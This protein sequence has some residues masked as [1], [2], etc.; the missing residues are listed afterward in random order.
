MCATLCCCMEADESQGDHRGWLRDW[1]RGEDQPTQRD[2]HEG[3]SQV[4][5]LL[6]Y[7]T[8]LVWDST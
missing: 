8:V 1:H 2:W 7:P 5:R 4:D 3:K 6:M